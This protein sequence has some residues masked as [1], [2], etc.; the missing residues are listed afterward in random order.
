MKR[1]FQ[2]RLQI[3]LLFILLAAVSVTALSGLLIYDSIRSAETAVLS[4]THHEL[5]VAN[6]DLGQQYLDRVASDP[7]WPALPPAAK[8]T[9]LRAI[10]EVVLRAYPGVEGGYFAGSQFLGYSFPTHENPAAKTDVPEAE[11]DAIERTVLQSERASSTE[12]VLQGG[13]YLVVIQAQTLVDTNAVAWTMKRLSRSHASVYRRPLLLALVLAALLSVGATL[14]MGIGLRQGV[15]D[16]QNGLRALE[17]DF[18]HHLPER[19]DELG[20][21]SRSIN[22]MAAVRRKL[23]TDLRREDRLRAV[24]RMV[25]GIAHEIRNP[26]NGIR[27][28]MQLLEQRVR[29]H[30][31]RHEDPELVIEEVDRM[32][33]LLGDLL[34]FQHRSKAQVAQVM[35]QAVLPVVERCIHLVEP[36]TSGSRVSIRRAG[37]EAQL[38]ACFDSRALTQALTN[39]LLNAIEAA[40]GNAEVD[41]ELDRDGEFV[42]IEVRDNGPGLSAEQQEHLFEAF[43]TT[44]PE[45]T[46]LG[47]AVSRELV[48]AM[49]GRLSYRDGQ[50]GATFVIQLPGVCHE[51]A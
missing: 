27:L 34:A 44:K 2:K 42:A 50:Q 7:N 38:H 28:S 8:N 41:V 46:G 36:Q 48:E 1:L 39:L 4:D 25:A 32:E 37:P 13:D 49:G 17:A 33:A 19:S 16:I 3:Q 31:I 24:G 51:Q 35:D 14:T 40:P 47:L 11:K 15:A 45:G 43:Y 29:N 21:I 18:T 26:L 10:S 9:S 22:R 5:A 30:A 20:S 6:H 12:R 23:E